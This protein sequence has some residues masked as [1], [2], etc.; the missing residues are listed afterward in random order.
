MDGGRFQKL[1]EAY[2]QRR[3]GLDHLSALGSQPGTDKATIG[4]PDAHD[5]SSDAIVFIAFTTQQSEYY[6]KLENDIDDCF[7]T[8]KTGIPND[9][10]RKVICCHTCWRLKPEEES[11]LRKKDPTR[12][13]L[14]GPETIALDL[15]HKYSDMAMDYLGIPVGDGSLLTVSTFVAAEDRSQYATPQSKELRDRDKEL[16]ELQRLIGENQVTVVRGPSGV[17]KTKLA[18]KAVSDYGQAHQLETFVL[19][20]NSCSD[21]RGDIRLFLWDTPAIVLVDDADQLTDLGSI[22]EASLQNDG[23]KLVMTVRDYAVNRV[24]KAVRRASGSGEL[25]LKLLGDKVVRNIVRDDYGVVNRHFL[26]Q[27]ER[28]AKGNVRLAVMAGMRGKKNGYRAIVSGYDIMDLF[29]DGLTNGLDDRKLLELSVYSAFGVCDLSP[30][31]RAYDWLLSHDFSD[32]ELC[33][34]A[35]D[36]SQRSI[37]DLLPRGSEGPIAVRFEQQNLRDYLVYRCF[38][39][40]RDLSLR[41]YIGDS[42]PGERRALVRVLN[43][44]LVVFGDKGTRDFVARE[45]QAVWD[46]IPN[47]DEGRRDEVMNVLH[48]LLPDDALLYAAKHVQGGAHSEIRDLGDYGRSHIGEPSTALAILC[49]RKGADDFKKKFLPLLVECV[50]KGCEPL[51]GY[52]GAFEEALAIDEFSPKREFR[53]ELEV[54]DALLASY[55]KHPSGNVGLALLKLAAQYL[56]TSIT[57]SAYDEKGIQIRQ[58]TLGFSEALASLRKVSFTALGCLLGSGDRR[59]RAEAISIARSYL[60]FAA[61]HELSDDQQ[62]FLKNDIPALIAAIPDGFLPVS[63]GELALW[64]RLLSICEALNIDKDGISANDIPTEFLTVRRLSEEDS[65]VDEACDVLRGWD[66]SRLTSLLNY[67]ATLSHDGGFNSY[68]VY[69][70]VDWVFAA[71][72]R[73]ACPDV[74][75]LDLFASYQQFVAAGLPVLGNLTVESLVASCGYQPLHKAALAGGSAAMIVAVDRCIPDGEIDNETC[76]EIISIAREGGPLLSANDVARIEGVVPGFARAYCHAARERLLK[77]PEAAASFFEPIDGEAVTTDFLA[78]AYA[79]VERELEG[80][81]LSAIVSE[82]FDFSGT[83]FAYLWHADPDHSIISRIVECALGMGFGAKGKALRRLGHVSLLG[84]D[85]QDAMIGAIDSII[86]LDRASADIEC[87]LD[88]SNPYLQNGFDTLGL[89]KKFVSMNMD[90]PNKIDAISSAISDLPPEQREDLL[91]FSLRSDK[92]GNLLRHIPLY[93]SSYNGS[94]EEGFVPQY[95]AELEMLKRLRDGLPSGTGYLK[96]GEFLK[97]AIEDKVKT[98]NAERWK[99]FHE[100]S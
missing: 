19:E 72:L 78:A 48:S 59:D 83:I 98:I 65:S 25:A 62:R 4:V 54:M 41:D 86:E 100:T 85:A 68:W 94:V 12:V 56:E 97:G 34:D 8:D 23:L 26:D 71:V 39:Q 37:L 2:V 95:E 77:D 93:P 7:D 79:G 96:H 99:V 40:T 30:G 5:V 42:I 61:G 44:L 88:P 16:A 81:Y 22:I 50:E 67:Y 92:E 69:V 10:I 15:S 90:D 57:T 84:D 33:S 43:T 14:V 58:F 49:E 20:S 76:A 6:S 80:V 64:E 27:I 28:I 91:A 52:K 38:V 13:E 89:L 36:L 45:C 55:R 66:L 35:R 1:G 60:P 31:F 3:Y 46:S 82:R 47:G 74:S 11:A 17:G 63:Y 70:G 29:F 18:L 24:R 87:V 9:Q 73:G 21:A 51:S 53:G 32:D 75:A